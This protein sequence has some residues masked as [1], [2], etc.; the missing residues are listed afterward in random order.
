MK[1]EG[2]VLFQSEWDNLNKIT[3]NIHGTNVINSA[4]PGGIMMP[5]TKANCDVTQ[6]RILPVLQRAKERSLGTEIPPTL[7]PLRIQHSQISITQLPEN[8]EH[9]QQSMSVYYIW[10]FSRAVRSHG[11]RPVP[12]IGGFISATG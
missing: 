11:I 10:L 4:G 12:A 6:E 8:I 7:P 9:W 2:N 3:S 5:E 1:G